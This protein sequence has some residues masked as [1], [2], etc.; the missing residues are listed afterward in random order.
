VYLINMY[1]RDEHV[2]CKFTVFSSAI[3]AMSVFTRSNCCGFTC[4]V[5]FPWYMYYFVFSG[6]GMSAQTSIAGP[7]AWHIYIYVRARDVVLM[8]I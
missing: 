4:V 3:S 5:I 7:V 6:K 1:I 8:Y 2:L